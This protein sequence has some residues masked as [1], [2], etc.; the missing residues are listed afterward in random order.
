MQLSSSTDS[1]SQSKPPTQKR[2][3]TR[4]PLSHST[5]QLDQGVHGLHSPPMSNSDTE[6]FKLFLIG[7]VYVFFNTYLTSINNQRV[8]SFKN[9]LNIFA[10]L[11]NNNYSYFKQLGGL[12][13]N[14]DFS[15][16]V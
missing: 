15:C 7:A 5:E 9:T 12:F 1:P 2:D 3:L 11:F 6:Y 13:Q 8:F 4:T 16:S 14:E 10:S